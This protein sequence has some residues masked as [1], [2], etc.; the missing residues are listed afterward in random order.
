MFNRHLL[1]FIIKDKVQML[2]LS[3]VNYAIENVF[4]NGDTPYFNNTILTKK[5]LLENWIIPLQASWL[6]NRLPQQASS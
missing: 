4:I 5:G 3:Q 2:P 1:A 6:K